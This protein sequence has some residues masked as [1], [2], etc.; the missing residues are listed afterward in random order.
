MLANSRHNPWYQPK[1]NERNMFPLEGEDAATIEPYH[2]NFRGSTVY[3]VGYGT[4]HEEVFTRGSRHE[5]FRI[6]VQK[7]T[8]LSHLSATMFSH[9]SM[10]AAL[11]G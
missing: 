5:A 6:A 8:T 3:V 1:P 7:E 9:E 4:E 10:I 2:G 11:G